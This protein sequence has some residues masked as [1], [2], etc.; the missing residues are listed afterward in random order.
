MREISSF[1]RSD[2]P[3]ELLLILAC[4]RITPNEKEA[5]QIE[6]LSQ[7]EIAWPDF[8]RLV[9]RH[10]VAPLVYHNLS[11]F[12]GKTMPAGVLGEL[13]ARFRSN[14]LKA[15]ANA[16]ELV[17]LSKRFQQNNIPVLSLKGSV[18]ALQ[19]YGN[20]ALR[21]AGDIDLLVDPSQEELADRLLQISYRRI[22]PGFRLTPSQRQRFLRLM[23]NFEYMDDQSNRPIEL[24]WQLIHNQPPHVMDLTRLH[25]RAS[26]VAV[27]G[28]TLPALSLPDNV[29]YL[30]SHGAFHFWYRLFWLVD[31]AE[32]I[33]GHP[34]ID[35][36][37][38][39]ILA[40]EVGMMHPLALGVILAY[41]LLDVPLPEAIR[42]Y[43]L[44]NQK[45]SYLARV[46]YWFMLGSRPLTPHLSL[47]LSSYIFRFRCANSFT[48]RLNILRNIFSCE[49]WKTLHF[50]DSLHFLYYVL[51]FPLW[52]HRRLGASQSK[53]GRFE[54]ERE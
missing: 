15:L 8:L 26:T 9:D 4:L 29:L 44:Q 48:E 35:W 28:S 21:Y 47:S 22:L 39:I 25:S 34:E 53:V 38:L 6:R 10:R 40:R 37:R 20:L 19:V 41:E 42:T 30:C 36:P 45:V 51:R 52:F 33:R 1:A 11:R 14:A 3:P 24:H 2:L 13:R 12:H 7:T 16:T 46:A 54:N 32:I 23:R 17:R 31:L 5:Q 49:D 43:A 27:A 18:L 50:P